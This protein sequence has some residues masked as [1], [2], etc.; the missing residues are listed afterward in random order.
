[1]DVRD[2]PI[3]EA[4]YSLPE[5]IACHSGPFCRVVLSTSI[6]SDTWHVDFPADAG[7]GVWRD[8]VGNLAGAVLDHEYPDA[9]KSYR[10][11]AEAVIG[12]R[13]LTDEE[14]R[15]IARRKELMTWPLW[16]NPE[17]TL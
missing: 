2:F 4:P 9:Y 6:G 10:W 3:A 8:A 14:R 11:E 7:E 16:P 15:I 17:R 1:M 12:K 5:W 13:T